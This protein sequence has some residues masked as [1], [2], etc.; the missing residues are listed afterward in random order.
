MD[1]EHQVARSVAYKTVD[2]FAGMMGRKLW[3]KNGPIARTDGYMIEVPFDDPNFYQL[4]EHEISH[5]LF[6]SD[7]IAK[8][9][10]VQEYTAKVTAVAGQRNVEL[11]KRTL[12]GALDMIIGILEDERVI[13]LWSLL[14]AGSGRILRRMAREDTEPYLASSHEDIITLMVLLAGGHEPNEGKLDRF[15]PYIIEALRKVYLRD[16]NATLVTA[17]WLVAMLVSE[18]IRQAQGLPPLPPPPRSPLTAPLGGP[19]GDEDE[20]D[21]PVEAAVPRM[22]YEEPEEPPQVPQEPTQESG[23][24]VE[25]VWQPPEVRAGPEERV[26]A[27]DAMIGQLGRG[28]RGLRDRFDDFQESKYKR[29]GEEQE[30]RRKAARAIRADVKDGNE[31]ERVLEASMADM[32][33]IVARV[34]S[35]IRNAVS[36][37]DWIR[38]DAYAKVVFHDASTLARIVPTAFEDEETVR[39]LRA[40]FYRIMGRRQRTMEDT[41]VELDVPTYITRKM[42]GDPLPIFRVDRTGRG[43]KTLVLIDRSSSMKGDRTEQAER[44]CRIITRALRFPFVEAHVW[45]FQSNDIGQVDITRFG[46]HMEGFDAAVGGVTPLHTAIRVASRFLEEG[47]EKKQLFVISDGFP[48]FHTRSG[49]NFSTKRLMTFVRGEVLRARSKGIGVTAVMIGSEQV[50]RGVVKIKTE[51]SP[52]KMGFMFGSS[53]HWRLIGTQSFGG[54]LVKLVTRSFVEYLRAG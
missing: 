17:K 32:R 27:L 14:Y 11:D 24:P 1:E 41:G 50:K 28:P 8:T 53:K 54:D 39:R 3:L 16:F 22:P 31:L 12:R 49:Y 38:K 33:E 2:V 20:G 6:G 44:G 26:A 40:A 45:G 21:Q 43:F 51:V 35:H 42:T 30:A 25:D 10:F 9:L 52:K 48:V 4:V 13:S 18:V 29:R 15:R 23:G 46:P 5:P 47:D 34:R 19:G 36:E 37:D 7:P